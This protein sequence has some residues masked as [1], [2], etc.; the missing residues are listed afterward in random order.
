MKTAPQKQRRNERERNRVN[1]VNVGFN[2]LRDRVPKLAVAP[3]KKMSKVETLREAVKYIQY[4][5]WLL[6]AEGAQVPLPSPSPPPHET[7]ASSNH[8]TYA[9]QLPSSAS[10]FQSQANFYG[11]H[12]LKS[13]E[14]PTS[15]SYFSDNSFDENK[16]F[17]TINGQN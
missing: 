1:Q 14:S 16:F 4:L 15:S 8:A 17:L 9:Q 10:F 11:H 12:S 3:N 13:E 2:R 7:T 5:Q 6:Q